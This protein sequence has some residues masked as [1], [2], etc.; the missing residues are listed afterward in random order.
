MSASDSR[1]S[2][3]STAARVKGL[4]RGR[5]ASSSSRIAAASSVPAASSDAAR[6]SAPRS[7]LRAR[8]R[9]R[10]RG[11][12]SRGR[13]RPRRPATAALHVGAGVEA[14]AVVAHRRHD[15]VP[16]LPRPQRV[17]AEAGQPRDGADRVARR[18]GQRLRHGLTVRAARPSR[19]AY[20]HRLWRTATRHPPV[21]R[22]PCRRRALCASS[23]SSVRGQSSLS[24]RDNARSDSSRPPVWQR[25]AVVGFVAGVDDP[26][27]GR[28]AV[29]A[30]LAVAAVNRHPVAKRRHLL[31]KLAAL[32]PRAAAR[33]TSAA[34]RASPRTGARPPRRTA[35]RQSSSATAAPRAGSR[36]SR[37]CRCR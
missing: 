13:A 10:P 30:R 25:A 32:P 26:L 23:S 21:R 20:V 29:R 35:P 9:I 28:A 14:A 3:R 19:Q 1:L 27:H 34:S 33:S 18:R 7:S 2:S 15:G 11:G 36:P 31:G 5:A 16:A 6:R 22:Q 17:D 4:Q 12:R 8:R 37:R 24:S